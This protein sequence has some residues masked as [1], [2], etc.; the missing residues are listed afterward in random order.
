[1][2]EEFSPQAAPPP[3]EKSLSA[4]TD[5]QRTV[6]KAE[7]ETGAASGA[8]GA[9]TRE[10][11]KA[12]LETLYATLDTAREKSKGQITPQARET[13]RII[14]AIDIQFNE[15][16]DAYRVQNKVV[17]A[18]DEAQAIAFNDRLDQFIVSLSVAQETNAVSE[19]EGTDRQ[20][21]PEIA[22]LGLFQGNEALVQAAIEKSGEEAIR[23]VCAN[24][25][26][27]SRVPASIHQEIFGRPP[28][29]MG[30]GVESTK[31]AILLANGTLENSP[32]A[33]LLQDPAVMIRGARDAA[34]SRS[35]RV[36]D[37]INALRGR[38]ENQMRQLAEETKDGTY[39]LLDLFTSKIDSAEKGIQL[40]V[41]EVKSLRSKIQERTSE[42]Q[43]V[44]NIT[45]TLDIA[46]EVG[47]AE[48]DRLSG[49][50]EESDRRLT[51]LLEK[52]GE[53]LQSVDASL[54]KRA[55]ESAVRLRDQKKL[56][57]VDE[58]L[59]FSDP[60]SPEALKKA[61]EQKLRESSAVD[62]LDQVRAKQTF[63]AG[64]F[65][66]YAPPK[67]SI[68][69][70]GR[71]VSGA[72]GV[73][74]RTTLNYTS[75]R[76]LNVIVTPQAQRVLE[77][78]L[79]GKEPV[80]LRPIS[81]QISVLEGSGRGAHSVLKNAP[82]DFIVQHTDIGFADASGNVVRDDG[83]TSFDVS[84]NENRTTIEKQIRNQKGFR[85]EGYR[86]T[87]PL[88][89]MEGKPYPYGLYTLKTQSGV[90][91]EG[92]T[93]AKDAIGLINAELSQGQT[94][95]LKRIPKG[96]ILKNKEGRSTG[97]HQ[98]V[99]AVDM[100]QKEDLAY[101]KINGDALTTRDIATG[102]ES[103]ASVKQT[104]KEQQG[105][106]RDIQRV[107][108]RNPA[109][110]GVKRSA[111]TI[112]QTVG[113]LQKF[114]AAGK[115]G[116]AREAFVQFARSEAKPTLEM[117]KNPQLRR[118]VE[119]A[120][121]ALR[122]LKGVNGVA[123]GGLEKKIDDQLKALDGFTAMLT[124]GRTQNLLE[125]IMDA[126][127]FD[128]DSWANFFTNQLPVI[129]ASIAFACAAA[130]LVVATCGTAAPFIAIAA[131]TALGGVIGAELGKEGVYAGR[132]LLDSRVKSGD[133]TFSGRSKTG[134]YIEGQKTFNEKTGTYENLEFFRD[135]ANPLARE[136]A[137][138]FAT[139]L[140]TMGIGNVVGGQLSK[141]LQ[142][143]EIVDRI[144]A[145]SGILQSLARRLASL[146]ENKE[147]LERA[148]GLKD[149]ITRALKSLPKEIGEELGEEAEEGI[150][151]K[152]LNQIDISLSGAD[153]ADGK[154]GLGTVA[155]VL[156][157]I[158]KSTR[159]GKS[160][161]SYDVR[162]KG[163]QELMARSQAIRAEAE[164]N[165]AIVTDL[166]KGI[167]SIRY[168]VEVNGKV[169]FEKVQMQPNVVARDAATELTDPSTPSA[170][171]KSESAHA[172]NLPADRLPHPIGQKSGVD[173]RRSDSETLTPE[174]ETYY[175]QERE[176]EQKL[177]EQKTKFEAA[178]TEFA[179][180]INI[181][182]GVD[183]LQKTLTNDG[184]LL[185]AMRD[186]ENNGQNPR[187]MPLSELAPLLE[188]SMGKDAFAPYG[189][190]F[191]QAG[192]KSLDVLTPVEIY[193][194]LGVQTKLAQAD[195]AVYGDQHIGLGRGAEL[196][197]FERNEV[198]RQRLA[199]DRKIGKGVKAIVDL[200]DFFDQTAV[201][202]KLTVNDKGETITPGEKIDSET[203]KVHVSV[204]EN[205]V[206]NEN[207]EVT[208]RV[209]G[210][211]AIV[212]RVENGN[213]DVQAGQPTKKGEMAKEETVKVTVNDQ[214]EII[215]TTEKQILIP[216]E[217][218]AEQVAAQRAE[219]A[220]IAGIPRENY[221]VV[222]G[223]H[224]L[225][226]TVPARDINGNLILRQKKMEN[227]TA[228]KAA[229]ITSDPLLQ[230]VL[231]NLEKDRPS[232]EQVE[233]IIQEASNVGKDKD[234]AFLRKFVDL[235][236]SA[237]DVKIW[238]E[239]HA[240]YGISV[241][242][243]SP[244]A[245]TT[246][247][248]PGE[249]FK[250][251]LRHFPVNGGEAIAKA[252]HGSDHGKL[253]AQERESDVGREIGA[254]IHQPAVVDGENH[255]PN[256]QG[257]HIRQQT[258][259]APALGGGT[260]AGDGESTNGFLLL[261]PDREVK[262]RQFD[263]VRKANPFSGRTIN[264]DQRLATYRREPRPFTGIGNL[265]PV[266]SSATGPVD[267]QNGHFLNAIKEHLEAT[268]ADLS[269]VKRIPKADGE[270]LIREGKIDRAV[271]PD[272][273]YILVKG[274][275][276]ITKNGADG[277]PTIVA[278][279]SSPSVLG[280]ISAV[281]GE[282]IASVSA[283]GDV[284]VL[285]IPGDVFRAMLKNPK[286]AAEY[287]AIVEKR[288]NDTGTVSDTVPVDADA[289]NK[290]GAFKEKLTAE[291]VAQN[292]EKNKKPATPTEIILDA[293]LK[294]ADS[295]PDELR[296]QTFNP[297][298]RVIIEGEGGTEC[299]VVLSGN[300]G[301]YK[302]IPES[303]T[304]LFLGERGPGDI[305]GEQAVVNSTE[306]RSADVRAQTPVQVLVVRPAL[307][308]ELIRNPKFKAAIDN[309]RIQ[310]TGNAFQK[311]AERKEKG[312]RREGALT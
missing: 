135:V 233:K 288:I 222:T 196:D 240:K 100:V 237:E 175:R 178:K 25:D 165:G 131:A 244:S 304:P 126:S 213:V 93:V 27:T 72:L 289:K 36:Q 309:M 40:S 298:Q 171:E 133:A 47:A 153:A 219:L 159:I 121:V 2:N 32:Y 88:K 17:P 19:K 261:G 275:V 141:L 297:M 210:Q 55:T 136:F 246:V 111:S 103:S 150:L 205:A 277:T 199:D 87:F 147:L 157:A 54:A 234:P 118:D 182:K 272:T 39:N 69:Y 48:G 146:N 92:V 14:R 200:G 85:L 9:P 20:Q 174:Q 79:P 189:K 160:T 285:E 99:L 292:T 255:T 252:V 281:I 268:P 306:T 251:V 41:D 191:A 256:A 270:V 22:S 119:E 203:G 188:L 56:S 226:D 144:T 134:A 138:G 143:S 247:T 21:K 97:I 34:R 253:K 303:D 67:G 95:V 257:E 125:T 65:E 68:T 307:M 76:S 223:N 259:L 300:V 230:N 211:P 177:A 217:K 114:L 110:N 164:S 50:T 242:T 78:L 127:K 96:I 128:A 10:E 218:V 232:L 263:P 154:L 12:K 172:K 299:Y 221:Y 94:L 264:E 75:G 51:Q 57:L 245:E 145:R 46:L 190:A 77:N 109:I 227:F 248:L 225:R 243:D 132:Q 148:T 167:L 84:Q 179:E 60:R 124:D 117:L 113:N 11:L 187:T 284:E 215:V 224:D 185:N 15:F 282:A 280:E 195:I 123:L 122:A 250:T 112:Q 74:S 61:V 166:G 236:P 170:T 29:Q 291:R 102:K 38:E 312:V 156:L 305:F 294:E 116:S 16:V 120:K 238:K 183:H 98:K 192:S 163:S 181:G 273:V 3:Q 269:Q 140:A 149:A 91:V 18:F 274:S 59:L 13:E 201:S 310:Q 43:V 101:A 302:N 193:E 161:I 239:A 216:F 220:D 241:A 137:I 186:L 66:K 283:K 115:A 28:A 271:Q 194:T 214:G 229:E 198:L 80:L 296:L 58:S 209:N 4:N 49:R 168:P 287:D 176:Y 202:A 286:V 106:T 130:A 228:E 169:E 158:A 37:D 265:G 62:I 139:T 279:R 254:D 311:K 104:D 180:K 52:Y 53:N 45:T 86:P 142:K 197:T 73:G 155:G 24:I 276:S 208:V 26:L 31:I 90:T 266:E 206:I 249:S 44:E 83:K 89:T 7:K 70:E 33:Y 267:A 290:L 105:N 278:E 235:E 173:A 151:E 152:F 162:G 1:M 35:T 63:R 82:S 81:S 231:M 293:L 107:L 71:D 8:G 262:F 42:L 64:L 30:N 207:G 308:A 5:E 260:Y 301:I 6:E 108:D 23:M 204:S 212:L 258:V 295:N 184:Q 129:I